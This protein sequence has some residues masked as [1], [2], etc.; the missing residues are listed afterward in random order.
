MVT[1]VIAASLSGEKGR[2]KINNIPLIGELSIT[3]NLCRRLGVPYQVNPD[4]SLD[5]VVDKFENPDATFDPYFENRTSILFA[6]PILSKLGIANISKPGGC[7]IGQRKV[8]FHIRGLELLGASVKEY[9]D[10]YHMEAPK[11]L[12]GNTIKLPFP[13]VGATE[14]LIIAASSAKG[15]TTIENGAVEPE[16][17]Q[18]VRI[19]QMS[20]VPIELLPERVFRIQGC[21][22]QIIGT[23]EVIP[24]RIEAFSWAVMAL[25]TKGDILVEGARQDDLTTPI[26]VLQRM[27]AGVDITSEG[28]R[29]Y[30]KRSLKPIDITTQVHPGFPTDMQQP[31][32]ILLSQCKG[33][34]KIHETIFE[35][36]FGY[37]ERLINNSIESKISISTECP[38]NQECRFAN[39][40]ASHV[41]VISGPINFTHKDLVIDDLRA[42]FAILTAG[43][44]SKNPVK[45]TNILSLYRGYEEP[46]RKLTE[47][48]GDAVLHF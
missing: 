32:C 11:G 44:L 16:I 21:P 30:Y 41:A 39:K 8:D 17:M 13:S 26:G 5:L 7:K 28:I 25:A 9:E 20:G 34:S 35:N 31:M 24:D 40:K 33:K 22:H 36:R 4:K 18:M 27:G 43:I 38:R 15:V 23:I 14:N 46:V 37:L 12:I 45:I 2:V 47:V 6:G 42:G 48:G 19:L 1:K 3:L 10:H 29:F